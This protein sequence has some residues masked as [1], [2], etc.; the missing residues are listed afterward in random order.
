MPP[1]IFWL[2]RVER[3]ELP[4]FHYTQ[5]LVKTARFYENYL[6]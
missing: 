2:Y 3:E 6:G 4:H 1:E 5:N